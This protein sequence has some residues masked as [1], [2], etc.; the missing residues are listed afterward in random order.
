MKIFLPLYERVIKWAAHAKAKWY[1]AAVSFAES[2]FFPIPPDVMLAPMVLAQR[3]QA[4]RLAMITTLASVAGG[5]LGYAI[6]Y[7]GLDMVMPLLQEHGYADK[8]ERAKSWFDEWGIWVVFLAGFTPVP[9]KVFTIAA[10]SLSMALL[11]F[12]LASLIGRG[13]RFFLVAGLI[14][15]GGPHIEAVLKRY[16]DLIGWVLILVIVLAYLWIQYAQ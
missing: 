7:F 11:P 5:M 16:V 9:Y 1:L 6:G 14:K 10:G 8:F 2:S 13:A 4:W 12:V 15:T 3:S